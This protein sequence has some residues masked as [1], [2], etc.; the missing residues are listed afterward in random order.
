MKKI[1]LTAFIFA[2]LISFTDAQ[3]R[4]LDKFSS[5]SVCGSIT[6]DLRQGSSPKAEIEMIKG[7][8]SDLILEVKDDELVI[9]FKNKKMG[10]WSNNR[11]ANIQLT[12]TELDEIDACAGA[13]VR[14][15]DVI[16]AESF[17]AEASSGASIKIDLKADDVDVSVSSGASVSI[18][19]NTES[20]DVDASSGASYKGG[21]FEADDVD[22]SVSSG[23][24]AKVW[25]KKSLDA[26]ASS[27]GSVKY[28][29]DPSEMDLDAGKYSG[30]SIRKM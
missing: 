25:A 11:K 30:G 13:A 3:T 26:E 12:Y 14:T 15:D 27:G 17:D 6:V 23:A 18:A 29:G 10:N 9:E 16:K 8:L 4:T 5:V 7:D 1:F 20:L 19:G 22:V 28:K 24:S 21:D 2:G